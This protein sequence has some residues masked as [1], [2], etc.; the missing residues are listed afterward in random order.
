MS[1]VPRT[2]ILRNFSQPKLEAPCKPSFN[3][4]EILER[5]LSMVP[6]EFQ[7]DPW[8]CRDQRNKFDEQKFNFFSTANYGLEEVR[9]LIKYKAFE[10]IPYILEELQRVAGRAGEFKFVR[11]VG[12]CLTQYWVYMCSLHDNSPV[13][14][15]KVI[16][17][18]SVIKDTYN[19]DGN[20][21]KAC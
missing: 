3:E 12:R 14:W 20:V 10:S 21:L 7:N 5:V 17:A 13:F 6:E 4:E 8:L 9:E 19:Q 1:S 16:K 15:K 11:K 18:L 2:N